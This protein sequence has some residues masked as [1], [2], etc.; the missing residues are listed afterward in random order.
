MINI[1]FEDDALHD[2]CVNL[3]RAEHTLG[4]VS[5]GALINL[6]S[7]ANAFENAHELID[8]LSEDAEISV[9]DSLIVAIGSDYRATLV[10]VGTRFGRNADGRIVWASVTR[11]KLVAISR[12]P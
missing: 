7:D 12:C 5:A 9:H 11:L 4:T 2:L 6:I 3:E 8:F 10:V 1:S